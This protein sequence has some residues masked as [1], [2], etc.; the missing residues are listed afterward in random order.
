MGTR[1]GEELADTQGEEATISDPASHSSALPENRT[2]AVPRSGSGE[3]GRWKEWF[4][5][6]YLLGLFLLS[7]L[8]GVFVVQ[9]PA[10]SYIGP[11]L[12]FD[13]LA[14]RLAVGIGFGP[15]AVV[16]P[17]YPFYLSVFYGWIGYSHEAVLLSHVLVLGFTA[18]TVALIVRYAGLSSRYAWV[19]GLL[20]AFFPQ[21][22][23]AIRHFSPVLILMLLWA[24]AALTWTRNRNGPHVLEAVF[25]GIVL[26]TMLLGRFGMWI[27]ALALLAARVAFPPSRKMFQVSRP[28]GASFTAGTS[29][30]SNASRSFGRRRLRPFLLA[31]LALTVMAGVATPWMVRNSRVHGEVVFMDSTWAMRWRAATVPGSHSIDYVIPGRFTVRPDHIP[32][33]ENRL[34]LGDVLGYVATDPGKVAHIWLLRASDI[35][36]FSGWNDAATLD[37]F[38]YEGIYFQLAQGIFYGMVLSLVLCW[39][40]LLRGRGQTERILF[41]SALAVFMTGVIGGGVGDTRLLLMP[42]LVPI[43]MRGAWGFLVQSRVRLRRRDGDPEEAWTPWRTFTNTDEYPWGVRP[44][45]GLAW[46]VLALGIVAIWLH[47]ISVS[48]PTYSG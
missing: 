31:I 27:P 13:Q 10:D 19:A 44:A 6:S 30:A 14:L 18:C 15:T 9:H 43:A 1:K 32:V 23:A 5:E 39:W 45:S 48:L 34:A 12:A 37:R 22:L 29:P 25:A 38:P 3:P 46:A 4:R 47:G 41:V 8:A 33:L 16:P 40:V 20:V 2:T 11:G 26:G 35:L 36:G 28:T 24:M 42:L 17:L 7:V 21:S